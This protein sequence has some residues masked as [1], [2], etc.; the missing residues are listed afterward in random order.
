MSY[1]VK[2]SSNNHNIDHS[3]GIILLK[4]VGLCRI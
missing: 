4:H 2:N 1:L 3:A